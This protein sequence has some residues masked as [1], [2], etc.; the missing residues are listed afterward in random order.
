MDQ[1][2]MASLL[3]TTQQ[4]IAKHL[5]N[6]FE[7]GELFKEENIRNLNNTTNSCIPPINPQSTRQPILYNFEAILSVAFSVNS[8]RALKVRRWANKTLVN[9]L[10]TDIKL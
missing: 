5:I 1:K 8:K 4:N 7:S 3:G 10:V 9:A 6:K 2:T